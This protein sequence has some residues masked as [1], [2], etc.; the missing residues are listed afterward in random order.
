MVK[1]G[2]IIARLDDSQFIAKLNTALQN[3]TLETSY[4]YLSKEVENYYESN[5]SAKKWKQ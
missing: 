2:D 4:A 5:P 3:E 1:E